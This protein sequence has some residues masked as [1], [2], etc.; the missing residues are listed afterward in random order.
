MNELVE[1]T[2]RRV[3]GYW[4]E[5]GMPDLYIGLGLAIY[6]A[7]SWWAI[8]AGTGWVV[9]LQSLFLPV[10]FGLAMIVMRRL[11]ESV[12]YPRTGFVSYARPARGRRV[13]QLLLVSA[14]AVVLAVVIV[15]TSG[16]GWTSRVDG[17]LPWLLPVLFT[18][19]LGAVSWYQGSVRYGLYAAAGLMAGLL[20]AAGGGARIG[21][22]QNAIAACVPFFIVLGAV[23]AVGGAWTLASYLRRTSRTEEAA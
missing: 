6:G 21:I 20:A 1:T 16:P 14:L 3:R 7:L 13:W 9:W 18:L 23:M 8:L 15:L 17:L 2:R 11:K 5:D 12:T 10:W 19:G 22:A 4:I